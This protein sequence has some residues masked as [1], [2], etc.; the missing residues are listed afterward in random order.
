MTYIKIQ[1]NHDISQNFDFLTIY[2]DISAIYR[3]ISPDIF[4]IFAIYHAFFPWYIA[5]INNIS[6]DISWYIAIYRNISRYIARYLD[7]SRYIAQFRHFCRYQLYFIQWKI[8]TFTQ[9][10]DLSIFNENPIWYFWFDIS[11]LQSWI[12]ISKSNDIFTMKWFED[13]FIQIYSRFS[14]IRTYKQ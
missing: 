5:K 12:D 13:L 4:F 8:R 6:G 2:S 10:N 11:Y 1:K 7:I 9:R 3:D 14:K